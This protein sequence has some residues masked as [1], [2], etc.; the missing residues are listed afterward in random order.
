MIIRDFGL[1]YLN[2]SFINRE[3]I[4]LV[5]NTDTNTKIQTQETR[6]CNGILYMLIY[7]RIEQLF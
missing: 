2:Y 5:S 3:E 6:T 4:L 7:Q 1:D